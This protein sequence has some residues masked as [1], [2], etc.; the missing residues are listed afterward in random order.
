MRWLWGCGVWG[1]GGGMFS[2]F[3]LLSLAKDVNDEA[4][5]EIRE[6]LQDGAVQVSG[7]ILW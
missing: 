6:L 2:G 3:K 4:L 5:A 1:A 7:C